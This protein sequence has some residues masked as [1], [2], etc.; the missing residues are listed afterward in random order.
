VKL[1]ILGGSFN[2]I[3]LGHLYLADSVLAAF[4]FDRLILVPANISPF[5]VGAGQ[6][7]PSVSASSQDRLDMALAS[8]AG[9]RRIGVVDLELRR[10]GVSYTIDTLNEIIERY[11]LKD[12]PGLILGDDLAADFAKW[13]DAEEIAQKARLIIARRVSA[14][15]GAFPFPHESLRNDIMELSS[16]MIRERIAKGNAWRSLVPRGA[17]I[18]IEER[19][20]YREGAGRENGAVSSLPSLSARVEDAV[21]SMVKSSRF[22]HSRNTALMARDLAL[23]WGLDP[24]AA[25]LAGIAHDMAKSLNDAELRTLARQD[26]KGFSKLEKKK[27]GLLHGRA[28]A[29]L[30]QERFGIHNRDVLEAVAVHTT[31]KAGM[32]KLAL[33]VY[34]ADKIEFSRPDVPAGLREL[35]ETAAPEEFF[36]AVLQDN[37][38]WLREGGMEIAED[39]RKLLGRATKT[40]ETRGDM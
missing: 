22:I 16:A 33:A 5:K 21:R 36:F 15:D 37:T 27:P 39:T 24:E 32:G 25:Y 17:A 4:D 28:A 2:P 7:E 26:G 12:K 9:D 18:I 6:P 13:K 29:V 3:H 23:R 8:I 19:G 11:G 14:A 38:R 10:G 31:G 30:L 34:I 1:A 40:S 35:A 20:L